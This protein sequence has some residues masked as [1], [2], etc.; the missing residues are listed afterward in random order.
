VPNHKTSG[1]HP[2][3]SS[4]WVAWHFFLA[5]GT[6]RGPR[7]PA[8]AVRTCVSWWVRHTRQHTLQSKL[9]STWW[10]QPIFVVNH[11]SREFCVLSRHSWSCSVESTLQRT[12]S[13][14]L[15]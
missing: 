1:L 6:L 3:T 4:C 13:T 15:Q 11:C 7:T 9:L 10:M 2:A 12:Q 14:E 8:V 5:V